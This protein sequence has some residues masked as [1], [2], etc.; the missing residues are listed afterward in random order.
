MLNPDYTT[1]MKGTPGGGTTTS[2]RLTTVLSYGA[3]LVLG[4][5]VYEIFAPFLEPLAWSAVLAIFFYPLHELLLRKMSPNKAALAST[6][7][8]TLVLI[9]PSII[10][11]GYA[12][13]QAIDAMTKIHQ[14]LAV[15]GQGP[16]QGLLMELAE[17]IRSRLPEAWRHS[18]ISGEIGRLAERAGAYLA[19]KVGAAV[20]NLT[21]FLLDLFIAILGLFYMFRDRQIIVRRV[22]TLLPFEEA[23]QSNMLLES[24]ELVFASVAVGLIIAGIQ[25]GLGGISFVIA[26]VPNALFWGVLMAFTSFIPVVGSA[27]VW[28]PVLVWLGLNGH[29][30]RALVVL[31]INGGLTA[32]ADNIVRPLLLRNRTRLN[33]FVLLIS[34]LGGLELFGLVGLVLGPTLVAAAMSIFQVYT[35]HRETTVAKQMKETP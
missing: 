11:L 35:V 2:D 23:I 26:R 3:L 20:R 8:V 28:V 7:I 6:T 29:W 22:K 15:Q 31:A 5:L 21:T 34:V 27:L 14:G 33:E 19:S 12:A 9:V 13:R 30:G 24:K 16:S 18:D 1:R 4:Y 10:L 32:M 25:G 17:R